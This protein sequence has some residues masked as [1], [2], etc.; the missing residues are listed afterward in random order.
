MA[1]NVHRL[2]VSHYSVADINTKW[3]RALAICTIVLLQL[4]RNHE[5]SFTVK[6]GELGTYI[7]VVLIFD[8]FDNLCKYLDRPVHF[9]ILNKPK[10]RDQKIVS[11]SCFTRYR[12]CNHEYHNHG[13]ALNRY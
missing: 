2:V 9:I 13:C 1:T 12:F 4:G 3:N 8:K 6:D 11:R 10:A 5:V 7:S